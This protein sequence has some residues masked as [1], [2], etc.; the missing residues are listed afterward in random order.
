[1][2]STRYKGKT[3]TISARLPV[4]LVASL[5]DVLDYR[6]EHIDTR[7]DA[8]CDALALWIALEQKAHG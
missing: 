7:S 3:Q 5:D 6:I 4:D 2:R 8:I 1:M